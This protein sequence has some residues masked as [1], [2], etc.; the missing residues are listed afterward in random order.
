[1]AD[2]DKKPEEKKSKAKPPEITQIHHRNPGVARGDYNAWQY[3]S[4]EEADRATGKRK[5]KPVTG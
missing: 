3:R 2:N 1:M 4:Q 5:G